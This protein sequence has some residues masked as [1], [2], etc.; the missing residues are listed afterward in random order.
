MLDFIRCC[1]V[2]AILLAMSGTETL[3]GGMRGDQFITTMDG[4]T[5]SGSNTAGL[6]FNLYFLAGGTATY[7]NVAGARVQGRWELGR[8]GAI[9][10]HWPV[11]VDAMEGCFRISFDGDDVIWRSNRTTGRGKLRGNVSESFATQGR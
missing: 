1:A 10:I 7:T 6:A 8:D 9:C 2:I 11:R 4:N 5:L 3:A